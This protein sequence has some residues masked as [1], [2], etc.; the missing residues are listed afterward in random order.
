LAIER[1]QFIKLVGGAVAVTPF[2]ARAQQASVPAVGVL[3]AQSQTS[4]ANVL[5]EWLKALAETGFTGGRNVAVEYRY[6]DGQGAQLPMLAAELIAKK[7]AVLVANTTP[8]ALA[9]KAATST[10][11]IVFVTG[12]D[13]VEAGLVTSFNRPG[14]N[15][16]GVTFMSNKLVAKRL[17]L[18][19]TVVP[20][21]API[22]M[23]AHSLNPN[24]VADVRDAQATMTTLGR[25]LLVER[26]ASISD[27]NAAVAKLVQSQ[28]AGLFIAPQADFRIWQTQILGLAERYALPT[29]FSNRD[30]VVAGALMSYGP[31]QADSYREAGHYTGRI[32]KGAKPADMPVLISTKFDF[33]INLKTARVLGLTIPPTMLALATTVIE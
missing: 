7:I 12:V 21:S 32:L 1:R 4:E 3:S 15:V 28:V 33:V 23:L 5:A 31:N 19:A 16:T 17:E 11:P 6:A 10:I 26:V 20:G 9:A 29:S 27:I 14:A 8:P 18:L 24:T 13:P 22:G 2:C 25:T 30:F